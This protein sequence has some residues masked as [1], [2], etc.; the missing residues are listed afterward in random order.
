MRVSAATGVGDGPIFARDEGTRLDKLPQANG[1][2]PLNRHQQFVYEAGVCDAE[3]N[4]EAE[5]PSDGKFS[6][7]VAATFVA[8]P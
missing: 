5:P 1:E 2:L 3:K 4:F 6:N 7:V 8:R